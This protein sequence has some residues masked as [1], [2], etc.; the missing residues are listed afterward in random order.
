MQIVWLF[1]QTNMPFFV[2]NIIFPFLEKYFFKVAITLPLWVLQCK[3]QSTLRGGGTW[4]GHQTDAW[5]FL[6]TFAKFGMIMSQTLQQCLV[7]ASE[8]FD[9]TSRSFLVLTP[10][11]RY[12]V[13][14]VAEFSLRIGFIWI[15]KHYRLLRFSFCIDWENHFPDKISQPWT[16]SSHSSLRTHAE[17]KTSA[18]A[19]RKHNI[20]QQN[21]FS[22]WAFGRREA[23]GQMRQD[24]LYR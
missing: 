5:Q 10:L 1:T 6:S 16:V 4:Q 19:P 12:V 20:R 13:L 24:H 3:S 22:E 8:R 2:E 14:M 7:S 21:N 18:L 15:E 23:F 17:N 11:R 9:T